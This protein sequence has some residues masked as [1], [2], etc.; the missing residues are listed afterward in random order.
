M[1]RRKN[2]FLLLLLFSGL[3]MLPQSKEQKKQV[4]KYL[5]EGQVY[6]YQEDYYKAWQAYRKVLQLDAKNKPGPL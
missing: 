1:L 5:K 2:S 3:L 6:F 4:K